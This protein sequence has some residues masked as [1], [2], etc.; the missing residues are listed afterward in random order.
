MEDVTKATVAEFDDHGG[1][2]GFAKL[3]SFAVDRREHRIVSPQLQTNIQNLLRD[4][5]TQLF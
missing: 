2:R 5:R 4:K 1:F 3:P